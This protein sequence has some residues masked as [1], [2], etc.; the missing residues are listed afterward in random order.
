MDA[1]LLPILAVIKNQCDLRLLNQLLEKE[2]HSLRSASSLDEFA[3]ILKREKAIGL[4]LIDPAGF[5]PAIWAPCQQLTDQ[6]VPWYL[7]APQARL[8]ISQEEALRRGGSGALAKPLAI[9]S[10][11]QLL[12]RIPVA[13]P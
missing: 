1:L 12:R 9:H 7:L 6:R 2:G 8:Q 13:L 11:L 5:E 3:T 4:A 10:L